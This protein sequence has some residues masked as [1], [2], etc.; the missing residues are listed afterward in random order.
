MTSPRSWVAGLIALGLLALTPPAGAREPSRPEPAPAVLG[1]DQGGELV[2]G[3]LS[4]DQQ[5]SRAL[6]RS[7]RSR[8]WPGRTIRYYESIPAKWDWSLGRAIQAWNSSGS[9][10]SFVKVASPAKAQLKISY[11]D[12]GGSDGMATVGYTPRAWVHLADGY[13]RVDATDPVMRVWVG[14]LFAHELGHV[15]SF[16]HTGASCSLMVAIF[17]LSTCP[18]LSRTPG[19]YACR[20]IDKPLLTR[21][22]GLYGGKAARPPANCLIDPLP[23]QLRNVRF[24][25]GQATGGPVRITWTKPTGVPAGSKVTITVGRTASCSTPPLSSET[26]HALP[27]AGGWSDPGHG[28]GT[29]CY[30]V[31]I[32]NR[33]GAARPSL[34][35]LVDRWAPV[36]AT[37][38]LGPLSWSATE[39][40]YRFTWTAP[41]GTHLEVLHGLDA[42]PTTCRSTYNQTISE[43]PYLDAGVWHVTPWAPE[44]CLAF[45]AVTDWGTVSPAR[46]VQ[47]TVPLPAVRPTVGTVTADPDAPGAF[48]AGATLPDTTYSVGI[49]VRPG[50][51]P[52]TAPGDATYFDGWEIAPGVYQ[53][54]N[55]QDGDNCAMFAA[56]DGWSRPGPVVMRPFT[57]T[58]AP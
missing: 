4:A 48:L 2:P 24:T 34:A 35:G 3:D 44:E 8:T 51:C 20:W 49:E 30:R 41:A 28:Q 16:G 27:A 42:T 14:R 33:Y 19:Y 40:Q 6:P 52:A 38:V 22:I 58:P 25:G 12:T 54:Y 53:F 7:A 56:L 50:T 39:R 21:F 37:P 26:D 18:V 17:N 32:A 43:T 5:F 29:H 46:D 1:A 11:G 47:V 23:P 45:F 36:P 10:I 55:E 9:R 57:W 13:R 31:R 15:L